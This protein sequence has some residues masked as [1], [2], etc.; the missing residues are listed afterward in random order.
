MGFGGGLVVSRVLGSIP[1]PSNLKFSYIE[2]GESKHARRLA[3]SDGR[4][5]GLN[6]GTALVQLRIE[7]LCFDLPLIQKVVD[8]KIQKLFSTFFF[9]S[10]LSFSTLFL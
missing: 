4:G 10:S 7:Q 5:M 8:K 2:P 1:A 9:V 6:L 3:C